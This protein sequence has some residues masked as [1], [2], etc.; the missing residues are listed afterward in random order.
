MNSQRLYGLPKL[1]IKVEDSSEKCDC[2]VRGLIFSALA[3]VIIL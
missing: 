3:R 1:S 2:G